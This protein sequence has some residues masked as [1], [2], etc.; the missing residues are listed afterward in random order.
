M[1]NEKHLLLLI[2]GSYTD[3][4]LSTETWQCGYRCSLNFGG[5]LD[6]VGTL[7]NDWNVVAASIS[8]TETDWTIDGNWSVQ[9]S[10][11]ET[12]A[13]DDW[14]NDQVAPA[15]ADWMLASTM[16]SHTQVDYLKVAPIGAPSGHYIPAPPY[17]AGSP[18][19]LTWT[20]SKP[21]GTNANP[22]LPLQVAAVLSHRT[23]QVGRRGRGRAFRAGFTTGAVGADGL[24]S[25]TMMSSVLAAEVAFLEA[26][27]LSLSVP[28]IIQVRPIITGAPFTSYGR[29][30]A[31]AMDQVPDTQRRRSKSITKSVSTASVSY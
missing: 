2:G 4:T 21:V 10:L 26:I 12:F 11:G 6:P 24:F 29:I 1:A 5:G 28:N 7:P 23:A 30:D 19:T 3:S 16:S 27:A 17:A 18:V 31:V 22:H 8:R 14:L 13:A 9:G 15:V 20:S 25:S